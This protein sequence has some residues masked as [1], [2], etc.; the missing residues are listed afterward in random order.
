MLDKV[1]AR[2]PVLAIDQEHELLLI[3]HK[4]PQIRTIGSV[5]F[6]KPAVQDVQLELRRKITQGWIALFQHQLSPELIPNDRRI[7]LAGSGLQTVI[8]FCLR[9]LIQCNALIMRSI[10]RCV[11]RRTFR[12]LNA[13]QHRC[14]RTPG[15]LDIKPDALAHILRRHLKADRAL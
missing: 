2:R 5:R 7:K 1:G 14:H 4:A 13:A 10:I 6:A 15:L 9:I 8:K 3:R 12:E 11:I